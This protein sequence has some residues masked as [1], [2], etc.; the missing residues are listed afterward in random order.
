MVLSPWFS[1]SGYFEGSASQSSSRERVAGRK[2]QVQFAGQSCGRKLQVRADDE[3]SLTSSPEKEGGEAHRA[4]PMSSF[5][6]AVKRLAPCS[7]L[8]NMYISQS[9][10]KGLLS[11]S[12]TE[13]VFSLGPSSS[14]RPAMYGCTS[15]VVM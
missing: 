11:R 10:L 7:L 1:G 13:L 5:G 14:G 3:T 8:M 15:M 2:S 4:F 12:I 9:H 6:S